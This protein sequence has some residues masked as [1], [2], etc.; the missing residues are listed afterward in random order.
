MTTVTNDDITDLC[1]DIDQ[2]D[3]EY[4]DGDPAVLVIEAHALL[5][6]AREMVKELLAER[7]GVPPWRPAGSGRSVQ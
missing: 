4:T 6:R 3:D 7:A 5:R 1:A 2:W